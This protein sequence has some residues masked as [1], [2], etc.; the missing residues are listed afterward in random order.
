ML[1]YFKIKMLFLFKSRRNNFFF[2]HLQLKKEHDTDYEY[3]VTQDPREWA[4][5]EKLLP[6]SSVPVPENKS[7]YPSGW[8]PMKGI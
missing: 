1:C 4:H 5:V 8:R 7:I 3:E 2:K 6:F